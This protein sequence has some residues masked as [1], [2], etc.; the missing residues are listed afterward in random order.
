MRDIRV[1]RRKLL[2]IMR[3]NRQEHVSEFGKAQAKYRELMI[4]EL[5]RRLADARA[6][7]PIVRAFYLPEPEDHSEDYDRAIAMLEMEVRDEVELNERDFRSYV[8]N[9]WE[10]AMA[11]NETARAYGTKVMP[12]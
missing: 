10:W 12:T 5:D 6:G 8:Q 11:W 4:A 3:D 1:D 7:G 2:K 9:R